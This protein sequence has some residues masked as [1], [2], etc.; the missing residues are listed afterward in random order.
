MQCIINL[1]MLVIQIALVTQWLE[2]WSSKPGVKSSI[3]FWGY[4]YLF[5]YFAFVLGFARI[6]RVYASYRFLTVAAVYCISRNFLRN[7]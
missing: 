2:H 1:K 3:L 6:I 7:I 4:G 5:L